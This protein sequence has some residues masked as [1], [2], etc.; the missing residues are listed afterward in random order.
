MCSRDVS[1][2][3]LGTTCG[4]V[5]AAIAYVKQVDNRLGLEYVVSNTIDSVVSFVDPRV[6]A[7]EDQIEVCVL[8]ESSEAEPTHVR[9]LY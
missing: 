5:L 1:E 7:R 4:A 2:K 8:R 3:I 9:W 6:R